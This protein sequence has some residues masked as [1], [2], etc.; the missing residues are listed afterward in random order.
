MLLLY[1]LHGWAAKIIRVVFFISLAL[2]LLEGTSILYDPA[3]LIGSDVGISIFLA[4]VTLGLRFWAASNDSSKKMRL[5]SGDS[6]ESLAKAHD[7]RQE[8][9]K[10]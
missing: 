10:S 7:R 8:H 3:H 1:E 5:E 9:P 6:S 2:L 4:I